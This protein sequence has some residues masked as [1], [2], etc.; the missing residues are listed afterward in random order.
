MQ[1]IEHTIQFTNVS[2]GTF[3]TKELVNRWDINGYV[4]RLFK[5]G[6]EISYETSK[7]ETGQLVVT[8]LV[9]YKG[10]QDRIIEA[11][12]KR[13]PVFKENGQVTFCEVVKKWKYPP[14]TLIKKDKV[15]IWSI[16]SWGKEILQ[17]FSQT[18]VVSARCHT[19]TARALHELTTHDSLQLERILQKDFTV[20]KIFDFEDFE[21]QMK[22][23]KELKLKAYRKIRK[24]EKEHSDFRLQVLSGLVLHAGISLGP[25]SLGMLFTGALI[26]SSDFVLKSFNKT[27][28][29][30]EILLPPQEPQVPSAFCVE[31]EPISVESYIDSRYRVSKFAWAVTLMAGPR[32]KLGNHISILIEGIASSVL[33]VNV[34]QD[35]HFLL[36]AH[37]KPPIST[38]LVTKKKF[39]EWKVR[40]IQ[41]SQIWMK[42]SKK[43]ENMIRCIA[44][45]RDE[46]DD[47]IAKGKT[48][49]WDIQ[50]EDS[51]TSNG[52]HSCITWAREKLNMVDVVLD[53][54]LTGKLITIS[55]L[56]TEP[57][58]YYDSLP[59]IVQI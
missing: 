50:G 47:I 23:R 40:K 10:T 53:K 24:Q 15:L 1:A 14:V 22:Q 3:Q 34:P 29:T 30:E 7:R 57:L 33:S 54:C 12:K 41:R 49:Q 46:H 25:V 59:S 13:H 26:L 18:T 21:S 19:E 38:K 28:I 36:Q 43:V 55:K 56:Y 16:D 4:V 48:I 27:R 31:I 9:P 6:S 42:S 8:C 5:V 20:T 51:I 11:L 52:K 45:E 58:E 37:F 2:Q 35:G 44:Q 17:P 32:G 39:D